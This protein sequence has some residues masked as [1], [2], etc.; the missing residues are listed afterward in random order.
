MYSV[1]REFG[2]SPDAAPET[3]PHSFSMSAPEEVEAP[4]LAGEDMAEPEGPLPP[5]DRQ[6]RR[7]PT[8]RLLGGEAD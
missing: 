6:G 7:V 4:D 1:H 2:I 3:T 5:R 8:D